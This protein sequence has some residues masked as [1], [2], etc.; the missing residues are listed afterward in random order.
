SAAAELAD[1]SQ[2]GVPRAPSECRHPCSPRAR[3][4]ARPTRRSP[5]L[6]PSLLASCPGLATR[7]GPGL[8]PLWGARGRTRDR[9][10]L[11]RERGDQRPERSA[12]VSVAALVLA[13][14]LVVIVVVLV[15]R[16]RD[17]CGGGR[18]RGGRDRR[19]ARL[20]P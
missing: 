13:V 8:E 10:V 9:G 20:D 2:G 1:P 5:Y 17:C 7:C 15:R 16:R 11:G 4:A 18:R 12:F 14:V 3:P 6:A 19:K